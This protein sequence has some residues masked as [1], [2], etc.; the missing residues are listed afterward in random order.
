[1]N[2][3]QITVGR[4]FFVREDRERYAESGTLRAVR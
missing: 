1:M 4:R 2:E 3:T